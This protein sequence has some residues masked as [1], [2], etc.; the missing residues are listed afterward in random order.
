M[1][2]ARFALGVVMLVAALAASVAFADKQTW[3]RALVTT[4]GALSA[5]PTVT[6]TA[7]TTSAAAIVAADT[8]VTIHRHTIVNRSSDEIGWWLATNCATGTHTVGNGTSVIPANQ[9]QQIPALSSLI[10]CGVSAGASSSVNVSTEK[11]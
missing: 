4:F 7:W 3:D 9:S 11:W 10:L 8:S 5:S 1:R 6:D 2:N